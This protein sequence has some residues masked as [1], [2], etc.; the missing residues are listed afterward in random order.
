MG[1]RDF[2]EVF[3]EMKNK[4]RKRKFNESENIDLYILEGTE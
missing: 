4:D 3:L 2:T 1:Y